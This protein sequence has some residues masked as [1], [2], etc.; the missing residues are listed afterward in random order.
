MNNDTKLSIDSLQSNDQH[1]AADD[2]IAEWS[3]SSPVAERIDWDHIA[4]VRLASQFA[5]DLIHNTGVSMA[6]EQYRLIRTRI[7]HDDRRP[8]TILVS[9]PGTGDGKS[10]TSI[11]LA[12]VLAL[13]EG[14]RTL[15]IDGDLRRPSVGQF[16]GIPERP[17]LTDVLRKGV[18]AATAMLS[19]EQNPKLHVMTAGTARHNVTELLDTPSLKRFMSLARTSFDFVIIDAP[20]VGAV[21]DYE[22]L[23]ACVDGVVLVVRPSNTDRLSCATVFQTVPAE[24]LL[25]AV[26]NCSQDWPFWRIPQSY[27][28]YARQRLE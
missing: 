2:S 27:Y 10:T 21:A 5:D 9:S 23:Q 11:N 19:C 20:P 6:G 18:S 12:Y 16:L 8:R 26:V 15:L 22:L 25:G 3:E 1:G 28:D 17:G 13:R 7:V 14:A 24:L 4:S